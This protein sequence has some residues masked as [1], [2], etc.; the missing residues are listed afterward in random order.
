V[1]L[2]PSDG[3]ILALVGGR[4]YGRSQFNRATQ[5]R[6]PPGSTMKPF[7]YLAA[8]E[9]SR[10]DDDFEF[11][12]ASVIEDTP[13]ELRAGGQPWRPA[14][15]DRRH[16]GA[17]TA[18][19]ALEQ[20]INVPAVRV[21]MQ[22]GL[23]AVVE[24]AERCGVESELEPVP[25]LALG[26]VGV[27]PLEL[28]GA[29]A[30][31]ANGGSRVRPHGWLALVDREGDPTSL[32]PARS[33]RAVGADSAYL[34]TDAL[35]GAVQR[36]TGRSAAA[37][38]FTGTAAGKTGT[39]D[40]LR[41]AWFVGYTT[42]VLALV[43]VGYDDNRPVGLTGA[44]GAL[45]IWVDLMRRIGADDVEN[46]PRPDGVVRRSVD[47]ATGQLATRRC[48]ESRQEWFIRETQPEQKCERH[49]GRKRDG[50]WKSLFGRN[51]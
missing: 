17:I 50:F 43:W 10:H 6:R 51:R 9:R 35:V 33:D 38:G 32:S 49:G 42:D 39:S 19:E 31:L 22:V 25:S 15:Y 24:M 41:D 47:P 44:S 2:R 20:S 13:L 18:R 28:A 27:T 21:G 12:L 4:D 5:A 46:F 8:L 36:G 40:G 26:S 30:A 45:P 11:T 3:A 48:P 29:Y 16:R 14:N 23:P 34:I 7:V 1:V 37:L